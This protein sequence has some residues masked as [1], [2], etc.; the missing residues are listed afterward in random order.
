MFYNIINTALR[1]IVWDFE[2]IPR[3]AF[4]YYSERCKYRKEEEEE[5]EEEEL[6]TLLQWVVGV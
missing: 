6:I 2:A 3:W 5:K 4:V 1:T